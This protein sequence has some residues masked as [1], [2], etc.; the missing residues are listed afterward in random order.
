MKKRSAVSSALFLICVAILAM[1]VIS[2]LSLDRRIARQV[3]SVAG[4][5]SRERTTEPPQSDDHNDPYSYED[6]YN[7]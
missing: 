4:G 1:S 6:P 7:Y 3:S 2:C 5:A